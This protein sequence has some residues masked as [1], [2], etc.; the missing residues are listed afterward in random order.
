[1]T[2]LKEIK[3]G[4]W[5]TKIRYGMFQLHITVWEESVKELLDGVNNLKLTS[6][7]RSRKYAILCIA[8]MI[9]KKL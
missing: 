1:M 5:Q 8:D 4:V 6:R 9:E 3:G 2:I 7:T